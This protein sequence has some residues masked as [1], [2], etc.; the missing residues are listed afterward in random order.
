[1][2]TTNTTRTFDRGEVVDHISR[3]LDAKKLVPEAFKGTDKFI[4]IVSWNIRW[5]DAQDPDRVAAIA[6]VM[7]QLN[8]DLFVLTEIAN[9]GALDTV[10]AELAARKAGFY[11][12]AYGSTGGQQ[13]VVLM[14]N[15]DWLRL[16]EAPTELFTDKPLSVLAEDGRKARVFPR[17]PLWAYFE[18]LP[19]PDEANAEGFNFEA[20][21][22]HL[23][24]QMPP[25]GFKGDRYG[26]KQRK[27]AATRLAKWL[28][29]K[30][31]HFDQDVIMVGDWNAATDKEEWAPLRK[32]EKKGEVT[33]SGINPTT[34]PTHLARLN[35]S[36]G[37]GTRLDL[38][39]VTTETKDQAVPDEMGVVIKW[40]FFEDLPKLDGATR[41]KLYETMRARFSD[42][43]PVVSRFYFVSKADLG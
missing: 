17:L 30:S 22:L 39:L 25:K 26:I 5:F 24:S 40:S 34:E 41:K 8:A 16:K 18:A 9:D 12:V 31:E 4:D 38:H 23:K 3:F 11:S 35:Q 15:R 10:V 32:I 19:P 2:A 42:H 43:L 37:G 28:T 14:W 21:G 36:G 1:M 27:A 13:R 33:F 20:V 29:L 7:E 6:D